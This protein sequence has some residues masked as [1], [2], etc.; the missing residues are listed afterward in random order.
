M[1]STSSNLILSPRDP[2]VRARV[3]LG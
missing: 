1:S 3:R 2:K